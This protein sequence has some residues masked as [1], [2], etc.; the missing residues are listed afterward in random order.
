VGRFDAKTDLTPCGEVSSP[1]QLQ[2]DRLPAFRKA[3]VEWSVIMAEGT[4]ENEH[5]SSVAPQNQVG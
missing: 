4:L 1:L 2:T 3:R 5:I